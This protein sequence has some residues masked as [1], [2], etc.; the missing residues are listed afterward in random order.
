ME[1]SQQAV[2]NAESKARQNVE[3]RIARPRLN[4]SEPHHEELQRP[5]RCR[6]DCNDVSIF[7]HRLLKKGSGVR[8]YLIALRP[9]DVFFGV[10][11]ADWKKGSDSNM[12]RDCRDFDSLGSHGLQHLPR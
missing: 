8:A 2:H 4:L 12:Q 7:P 10:F 11:R 9:K 1:V 6:P 5:G 3:V